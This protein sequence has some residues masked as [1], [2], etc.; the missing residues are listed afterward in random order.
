[1]VYHGIDLSFE[2]L[3]IRLQKSWK[4]TTITMMYIELLNTASSSL[5]LM[6]ASL[7]R[8]AK[9]AASEFAVITGAVFLISW[10]AP[11]LFVH[12]DA[13]C[14]ISLIVSVAEEGY[15]GEKALE[16]ANE[17]VKERKVAGFSLMV[18]TVI[19]DQAV[20]K[21][22]RF[23]SAISLVQLLPMF[24]TYLLYTSFYYDSKKKFCPKGEKIL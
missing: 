14:K 20:C 3:H 4:Q 19:I 9:G 7:G 11:L 10:L 13:A 5:L 16:R 8:S 18:L 1:M 6:L 23:W 12:S 2:N 22:C 24:F 21:M 15:K 17:L